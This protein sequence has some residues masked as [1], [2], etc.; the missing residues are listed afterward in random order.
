[1]NRLTGE[2]VVAHKS[3]LNLYQPKGSGY[4]LIEVDNF[5][6]PRTGARCAFH[7]NSGD[8]VVV[9]DTEGFCIFGRGDNKYTKKIIDNFGTWHSGSGLAVDQKKGDVF[10][11]AGHA[12]GGGRP[13][14][15]PV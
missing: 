10:V 12:G 15:R 6:K 2:I 8:I 1:M 13:I 5:S 11:V 7:E 4:S 14:S 9:N 3:G